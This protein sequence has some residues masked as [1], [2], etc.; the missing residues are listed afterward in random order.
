MKNALSILSAVACTAGAAVFAQ[1]TPASQP[2]Q[3]AAP[4]GVTA[5]ATPAREVEPPAPETLAPAATPAP[6]AAPAPAPAAAP[7]APAPAAAPAP[8]CK[9]C[10]TEPRAD[11][12]TER[13]AQQTLQ[14]I[15]DKYASRGMSVLMAK[16]GKAFPDAAGVAVGQSTEIIDGRGQRTVTVTITNK[17]GKSTTYSLI[18]PV[19]DEANAPAA[20]QAA[21]PGAARV[22]P[23]GPHAGGFHDGMSEAMLRRVASIC[24]LLAGV[25]DKATADAAAP[26][27][28][29]Q[30]LD[31]E[32]MIAASRSRTLPQR[33][34]ARMIRTYNDAMEA[35][36]NKMENL[37]T[38]MAAKD[39][40]GSSA[41][42]EVAQKFC[43]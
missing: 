31:L 36:I 33:Y 39:Y 34:L 24:D 6:A 1:Q 19:G 8:T 32:N 22:Q 11:T 23:R 38:E 27:L 2:G 26:Q 18:S 35:G 12:P 42:K 5:A 16:T 25:H 20:P 13:K 7:A 3:P 14:K 21:T 40:Y 29:K 17:D 9:V 37:I 10:P 15:V 4:E 41:M 28:D 30:C 43:R